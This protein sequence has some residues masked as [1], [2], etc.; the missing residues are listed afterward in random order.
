[1]ILVTGGVGFIGSCLAA[2]LE[3]RGTGPLVL[4]DWLESGEKWRNIAKRLPE[5]IIAPPHLLDFLQG[6]AS[7]PTAILHMGAISATTENDGDR[8]LAQNFEYSRTLWDYCARQ[9]VRFIYASSAATYGDGSNGFD[10]DGSAGALFNLRPLNLYGWSK[11]YFDRWVR[12]QLDSGKARPPQHAGLKFFNVFGPNEYH[13]GGQRSVAHQ[14]FP[15]AMRG[16]AFPLF[17]SDHEGIP[18]G[19][20]KRDFIWVGDVVGVMLW[21]L[22]TP[23]V[24]GLFNVGSGEARSFADLSAAVYRA[25]GKAPQL[26]F[27]PM[28]QELK[29]RYQYFTEARMERLRGAGYDRPFTSLEDAVARY[30]KDYLLQTDP[31]C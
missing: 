17:E 24:S 30:V 16:E 11:H 5:K 1:M 22:D 9:G 15:F 4:C 6:L 29:G 25:C 14:I 26:S 19:G 13:K 7:P 21:L 8:I 12:H 18:H 10:D 3:A 27:R 28:P 2:A 23:K 31:Y 20:Q